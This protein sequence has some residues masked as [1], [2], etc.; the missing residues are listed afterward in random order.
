MCAYIRDSASA[1]V[2]VRTRMLSSSFSTVLWIVYSLCLRTRHHLLCYTTND[3][4][5]LYL[6]FCL[7]LCQ[8]KNVDTCHLKFASEWH[9]LVQIVAELLDCWTCVWKD[10]PQKYDVQPNEFLRI[11]KIQERT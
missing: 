3:S 5:C 2:C 6:L 4:M 11:Y 1:C 8:H 7:I 9:V 10:G